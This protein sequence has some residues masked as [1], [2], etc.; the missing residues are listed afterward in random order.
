MGDHIFTDVNIAK[1]GMR[2]RTCV[3]LQE[4]EREIA[5]V[6]QGREVA[7]RL[8]EMRRQKDQLASVCNYLLNELPGTTRAG[9]PR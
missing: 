1:R 9:A 6:W 2:W 5:G 8:K 3:V 7:R 4:L